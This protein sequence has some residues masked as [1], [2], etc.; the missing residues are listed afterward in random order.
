MKR[1][2][3]LIAFA[4]IIIIAFGLPFLIPLPDTGVNPS[5]LAIDGGRFITVD[6]LQ[7]YVVERGPDDG[8]AV[9]FIHG[10][11]GSTYTWRNQLDVL[12]AAGFHAIAFDRPGAG[13][14]DK[15][16]GINYSHE[17]QATFTADLMD[18]LNIP[19]AVIVGHSAGGNVLAHFALSHADRMERLVI[20]DGAIV[21]Q[22]GPPSFVGGIVAFPPIARWA[23]IG[24]RALFNQDRLAASLRGFYADPNTATPET[25]AGYWRTFQTNG[26]DIGLIGLTRDSAGNKVAETQ[27]KTISASTLLLWGERDTVTPL[28]QGEQLRDLLPNVSLSVIPAAGHQPMEEASSAFNEQLLTFLGQP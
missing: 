5:S 12:A 11:F 23:Q 15:P 8:T 27:I 9:I 1:R 14:T 13:L 18:A 17:S 28:A 24:V 16:A 6:G 22:S 25:I 21:G 10:L 19:K 26:W 20:V 3:I 7:T 2:R 4:L